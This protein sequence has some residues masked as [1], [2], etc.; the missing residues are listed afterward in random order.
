MI[1]ITYNTSVET[2]EEINL[3]D[4]ISDIYQNAGK[5]I[6]IEKVRNKNSTFYN[7]ILNTGQS[8]P[9]IR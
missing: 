6:D 5:V 8:I 4:E 2:L 1:T 9:V 7:Y 3:G